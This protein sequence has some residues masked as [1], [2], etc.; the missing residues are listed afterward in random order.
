MVHLV[1]MAGEAAKS[2]DRCDERVV[3]VV[4]SEIRL[5]P[6]LNPSPHHPRPNILDG[7]P[8]G[9]SSRLKQWLTLIV[10]TKVNDGTAKLHYVG[11]SPPALSGRAVR[12]ARC[13]WDGRRHP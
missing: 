8:S 10:V 12:C 4:Y 6:D 2:R 9:T 1:P 3:N 7:F 11:F 13:S 5:V